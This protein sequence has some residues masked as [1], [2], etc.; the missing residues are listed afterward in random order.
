[1]F[2]TC[3]AVEGFGMQAVMWTLSQEEMGPL[4][5]APGGGGGYRLVVQGLGSK[6]GRLWTRGPS[7]GFGGRRC[8]R[9]TS[10]ACRAVGR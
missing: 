5:W 9:R 4:G 2:W 10:R 6:P 7:P 8:P 3:G 1:M